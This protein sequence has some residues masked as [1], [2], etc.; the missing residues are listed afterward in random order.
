MPFLDRQIYPL[1]VYDSVINLQSTTST[2]VGFSGCDLFLITI[3]KILFPPPS[4]ECT[5]TL[6]DYFYNPGSKQLATMMYKSFVLSVLMFCMPVLFPSLYINVTSSIQRLD[7]D[8]IADFDTSKLVK[9]TALKLF[10]DDDHFI[11]SIN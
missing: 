10:H 11:N 7:L 2:K 1:F 9:T 8:S 6:S 4:K 3:W 5:G